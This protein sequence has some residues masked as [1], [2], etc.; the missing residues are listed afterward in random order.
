MAICP[1]T[2]HIPASV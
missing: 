1:M 2:G